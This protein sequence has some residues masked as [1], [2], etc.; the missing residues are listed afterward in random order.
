MNFLSIVNPAILLPLVPAPCASYAKSFHSVVDQVKR[1]NGMALTYPGLK[2]ERNRLRFY[3]QMNRRLVP[4]ISCLDD[5]KS[6]VLE[7]YQEDKDMTDAQIKTF[8]DD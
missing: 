7:Y 5:H 1:F 2:T 8:S 3:H 4:L 6:E